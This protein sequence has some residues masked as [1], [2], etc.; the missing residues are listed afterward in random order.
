MIQNYIDVPS[1][2]PIQFIWKNLRYYLDTC[3]VA[4]RIAEIHKIE[5]K[6]KKNADKQAEQLGY[7]IRQAEEYFKASEQVG[8]PTRPTLMYYGAVSLSKAL[9]LLR[10][11][12]EYSFDQ[13]RKANKHQHHGLELERGFKQYRKGDGAAAFL[14]SLTCKPFRHPTSHTPWGHFALFYESL[15]NTANRVKCEWISRVGRVILNMVRTTTYSFDLC[16]KRPLDSVI[17]GTFTVFGLLRS[18]PDLVHVFRQYGIRPLIAEGAIDVEVQDGTPGKGEAWKL[19][20]EK[21]WYTITG[22]N[23]REIALFVSLFDRLN[24]LIKLQ[25]TEGDTLGFSLER[26]SGE[27]AGTNI[28]IPDCT[29]DISGRQYFIMD[30]ESYILEPAAMLVG[31]FCLGM[32]ARYH[33][34]IWM[35]AIDEDVRI[36]ELVDS[37]LN[38]CHR[39]FP[40]LILD[41]LS[42]THHHV[43]LS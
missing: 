1:E 31:L 38:V 34:D 40:N 26:R 7:C 37:F 9:V 36:A 17:E 33:A 18:L 3:Y 32:V 28:N 13:L 2:N 12:G 35:Q 16:S 11:S 27:L 22:L 29:C 39:K 4:D 24:P 5:P 43:H 23:E 30:P 10:L 19:T 42:D 25:M 8:L 20:I 15:T 21:R 41:Q 14:Q 6:H